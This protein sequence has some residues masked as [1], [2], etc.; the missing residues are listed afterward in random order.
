MDTDWK[1]RAESAEKTVEVLKRRVLALYAGDATSF[2]RQLRRAERR[3]EDA[4]RKRELTEMRAAEL[5][6]HSEELEREVAARTR[7]IR[8]ILD[9]VMSGF[10][11]VGPDRIVRS[12]YT[13]SCARL[14]GTTHVAGAPIEQLLRMTDTAL[15]ELVALG[16]EQFFEDVLPDTVCLE[17]IPVVYTIGKTT[18][19]VEWRPLRS[20]V[21]TPEAVLL[22]ITDVSKQLEAERDARENKRLVRIVGQRE[23]FRTC[24]GDARELLRAAMDASE[25]G[26]DV[27]VR[28][29]LHT[30][31]GNAGAYDLE[32]VVRVCHQAESLRS[33]GGDDVAAV[34]HALRQFVDRHGKVLDF[35]YDEVET[36]F[37]VTETHLNGLMKMSATRPEPADIARWTARVVLKPIDHVL[38]PVESFVSNTAQR[39]GKAVGFEVLGGET[40]VDSYLLKPVVN[41]LCHLLR[42]AVAHGVEPVDERGVKPE[43]A[44]VRIVV[45][46][47]DRDWTIRVSDDGRGIDTRAL[48][49]KAVE[50]GAISAQEAAALSPYARCEL[51]FIDGVST[52]TEVTEVSGRGVGMAAV[53]AAVEAVGGR[54][55]I[56]SIPGVGT[57]VD[58]ILPKPAA[59]RNDSRRPARTPEALA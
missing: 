24:V 56:Q 44:L 35:R 13:A 8:V 14:L 7:D 5:K 23:T 29:A 30:V 40:V 39:F 38:G 25:A 31:K 22:S 58:L 21:G 2:Q 47:T 1:Q 10:L 53:R 41:N 9:N 34:E 46:E 55:A 16:F 11:I 57:D 32:D 6:R 52:A 28:R 3:Q 12:G 42:N 19:H 48:V 49:A 33:V 4:R 50:R 17:Q 36:T 26:D 54:V 37:P 27:F 59:L 43:R 20:V 18:L 15:M 45:S 51:A